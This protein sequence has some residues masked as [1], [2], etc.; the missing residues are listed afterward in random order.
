MLRNL[1]KEKLPGH[2]FLGNYSYSMGPGC[3]A[4]HAVSPLNK[5]SAELQ[6]CF[7]MRTVLGMCMRT[8]DCASEAHVV[9]LTVGA[10]L[11]LTC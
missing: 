4:L 6:M 9:G 11:F 7:L 5:T 2:T 8:L 3:A 10:A 1:G